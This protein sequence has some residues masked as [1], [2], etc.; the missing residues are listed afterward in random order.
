M[1]TAEASVNVAADPQTAW[2]YVSNYQ[3]FD[4]FMPHIKEIKLL[5]GDTS[6]WHLSGPLGIPVT[7]QAITSIKEAPSHLA[8]H[9]TKG[10]IDTKG[11][12]KIEPSNTGS[13]ITVHMEYQP[14]LG[15][16]G[17]AFAT[18]FKDPQKMLE[19]GVEKLGQILH[20][21]E[22]RVKDKDET[23]QSEQT[24]GMTDPS[25][26]TSMTSSNADVAHGM[27]GGLSS[28][29]G[30][31]TGLTEPGMNDAG[32]DDTRGDPSLAGSS[33]RD[34]SDNSDLETRRNDTTRSRM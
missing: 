3:N 8:W 21:G 30:S 33:L 19:D 32:P 28:G 25:G 27:G 17:E 2:E 12:I 4:Q 14:P 20:G 26:S 10:T 22:V 31:G 18:L 5:S 29:S 13:R 34:S 15:A 23:R 24:R 7:W 16:L 6:E 11:F 9:S 1:Y